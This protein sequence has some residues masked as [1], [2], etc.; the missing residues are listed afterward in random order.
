MCVWSSGYWVLKGN[1]PGGIRQFNYIN[2]VAAAFEGLFA[3]QFQHVT[4]KDPVTNQPVEPGSVLLTQLGFT[5]SVAS[6][7]G[8]LIAYFGGFL[9]LRYIALKFSNKKN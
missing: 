7:V 1:M 6:R 4:F 8:I 3:N 9:I 2:P 5:S